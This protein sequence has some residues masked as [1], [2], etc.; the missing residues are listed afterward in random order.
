MSKKAS[1]NTYSL[2]RPNSEQTGLIK[3]PI[4]YLLSFIN[5]CYVWFA[6]DASQGNY[7]F[8]FCYRPSW[9][10][11]IDE[12]QLMQSEYSISQSMRYAVNFKQAD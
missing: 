9:T 7:L 4:V 3:I 11:N 12:Q 5:D 2:K 6:F 10:S 8:F 1:G